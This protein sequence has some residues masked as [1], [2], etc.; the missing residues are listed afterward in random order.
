M[1]NMGN[2]VG[3][4]KKKLT[5]AGANVV[6]FSRVSDLVQSNLSVNINGQFIMQVSRGEGV[7]FSLLAS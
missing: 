1:R 2:E 3:S 7:A 5:P 4:K 6:S